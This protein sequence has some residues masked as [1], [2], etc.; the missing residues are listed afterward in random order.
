MRRAVPLLRS[1][2]Q[3]SHMPGVIEGNQGHTYGLSFWLPFQGTGVYSYDTYDFRSFLLASFGMGTLTPGNTSAQRQAHREARFVGPFFLEGDYH[4]LTPY[5]LARDR[6]IAWQFHRPDLDQSVVQAFRRPDA[7]DATL[8]IH[9]RA[10]DPARQ[11]RIR[12]LDGGEEI[13]SGAELARGYTITLTQKPAAALL[14][15]EPAD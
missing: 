6:W 2:F 12:N 3:F 10:L 15:L 4:P 7:A 5:S 8:R 13:R 11:Y 1:D 9:P 14:H